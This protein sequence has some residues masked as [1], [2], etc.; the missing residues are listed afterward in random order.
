MFVLDTCMQRS[1]QVSKL[2][3]RD[4]L[5]KM[6]CN[7]LIE[8][9]CE[10][11][12]F[13][14]SFSSGLFSGVGA[15]TC[16]LRWTAFLWTVN[17]ISCA[18]GM[19]VSEQTGICVCCLHFPSHEYVCVNMKFL[20]TE[21]VLSYCCW[22]QEQNGCMATSYVPIKHVEDNIFVL[23]LCYAELFKRVFLF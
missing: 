11:V 16:L 4:S 20:D 9:N 22:S 1:I 8:L 10:I 5:F 6:W 7:F 17:S 3:I 12:S 15:M 14:S 2:S 19:A 23:M 13:T 21:S 18:L